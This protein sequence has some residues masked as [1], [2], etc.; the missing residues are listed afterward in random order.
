MKFM[1]DVDARIRPDVDGWRVRGRPCGFIGCVALQANGGGRSS[2]MIHG[3][4]QLPERNLWPGGC[5]SPGPRCSVPTSPRGAAVLMTP[6][7]GLLR[8][9][10]ARWRQREAC[11]LGIG[12]RAPQP[13]WGAR[14]CRTNWTGFA[15]AVHLEKAATVAVK[16][17]PSS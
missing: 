9:D 17:W 3:L 10:R 2:G 8:S 14:P 13:R 16:R 5:R 11:G 12:A 1:M 6:P 15:P 7:I 4:S